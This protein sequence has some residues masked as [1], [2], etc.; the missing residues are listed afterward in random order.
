MNND[1]E[2]LCDIYRATRMGAETLDNLLS[3]TEGS[4]IENELMREKRVY[5][6]FQNKTDKIIK[7]RNESP[8]PINRAQMKMA[9]MGINMNIMFDQSDSHIA[10]IVIQGN[11]MGI[12]GMSKTINSHKN[13][14]D[15]IS[16]LAYELVDIQRK[17]IDNL[18]RYL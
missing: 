6:E 3:K 14:D 13:V 9:K 2:F 18:L 8:K 4:D 17:N 11:N 1:S 16:D 5:R 7:E 12:I 15:D 10:D